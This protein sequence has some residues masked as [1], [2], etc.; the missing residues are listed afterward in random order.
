MEGPGK[1]PHRHLGWRLA[2]RLPGLRARGTHDVAEDR[3]KPCVLGRSIDSFLLRRS[4][5]YG[6][7]SW[8]GRRISAHRLLRKQTASLA[9]RGMV[10]FLLGVLAWLLVCSDV[11]RAGG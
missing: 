11:G 6:K 8:R 5:G 2:P 4:A 10:C 3:R 7:E 9:F 1:T